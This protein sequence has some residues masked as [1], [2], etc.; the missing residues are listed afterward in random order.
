M[1]RRRVST[2]EPLSRPEKAWN[3]FVELVYRACLL[4]TFFLMP[5]TLGY[6]IYYTFINV[7]V[8]RAIM[9]SVLLF[10]LVE[11]NIRMKGGASR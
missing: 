9:C 4:C 3:A 1:S 8:D 5:V 2:A 6:V 7:T 10:I 11:T